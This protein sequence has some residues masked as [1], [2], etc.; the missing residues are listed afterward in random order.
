MKKL[1]LSSNKF[2]SFPFDALQDLTSLEVIDLS[3]NLIE[4]LS[5]KMLQVMRG[6]EV[7][8]CDWF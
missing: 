2:T 4:E 3:R 1:N 7:I 5:P 6:D 8:E